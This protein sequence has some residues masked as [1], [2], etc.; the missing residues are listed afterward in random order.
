MKIEGV[1]LGHWFTK[2]IEFVKN[3]ILRANL[4]KAADKHIRYVINVMSLK[5]DHEK[6]YIN[7]GTE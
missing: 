4:N 6:A 3:R 5:I 7:L 2:G 1:S